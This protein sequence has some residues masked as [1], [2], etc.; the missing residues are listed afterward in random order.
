MKHSSAKKVEESV[1]WEEI[2]APPTKPKRPLLDLPQILVYVDF[3]QHTV[4]EGERRDGTVYYIPFDAEEG[5][6]VK[7]LPIKDFDHKY[8][9]LLDYPVDRAA[10]L[11]LQYATHLGATREALNYLGKYT[12]ITQGEI[13]M[14]TSK[15]N[16]DEKLAAQKTAEKKPV[17]AKKE[18]PKKAEPKAATKKVEPKAKGEKKETASQ[19]F[20]DLIMEGK[21]TDEQIFKKVQAKFGL[22]DNKAGYVKWYRNDLRKNGVKNV[23]DPVVK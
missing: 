6:L 4:I 8:K 1:P 16:T 23:P 14:A 13:A 2:P 10:K 3:S 9:P 15:K 11:Y 22:D 12:Q 5:L 7:R 19:M 17:P 20:K 18:T 21:L